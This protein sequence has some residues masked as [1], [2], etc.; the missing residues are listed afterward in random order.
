MG[1]EIVKDKTY[2]LGRIYLFGDRYQEF[3]T[4]ADILGIAAEFGIQRSYILTFHDAGYSFP[5]L[6]HDPGKIVTGRK[7]QFRCERITSMLCHH[8]S[9]ANASGQYTN[10][11]LSRSRIW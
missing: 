4:Y 5:Q 7:R 2:D 1:C 11:G 8:I 9:E 3:G 6:I 10:S